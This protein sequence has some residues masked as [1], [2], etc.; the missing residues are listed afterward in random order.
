MTMRTAKALEVRADNKMAK[1]YRVSIVFDVIIEA[2]SEEEA[3]EKAGDLE[4][5]SGYVEDSF[6]VAG[7]EPYAY[8]S[9][10]YCH[11]CKDLSGPKEGL[12]VCPVCGEDKDIE[13][14]SQ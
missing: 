14:N 8:A 5:P 6:D 4:L 13:R 11:T 3:E 1:K 10:I 12:T 7:I 9:T 2:A